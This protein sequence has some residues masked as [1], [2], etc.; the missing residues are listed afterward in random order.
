MRAV[1][2][3]EDVIVGGEGAR[4]LLE[5]EQWEWTVS[6][7]QVSES[8]GGRSGG[9]PWRAR[10]FGGA[11]RELGCTGQEGRHQRP[12]AVPHILPPA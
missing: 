10:S 3:G 6:V 5:A 1:G 8:G 4:V 12:H 2:S 7:E 11:D 9:R